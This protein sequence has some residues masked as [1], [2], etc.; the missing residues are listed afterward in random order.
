[1]ADTVVSNL[2]EFKLRR[3]PEGIRV[4]VTSTPEFEQSLRTRSKADRVDRCSADGK[5]VYLWNIRQNPTPDDAELGY[6]L[7]MEG[8]S[9]PGGATCVF[10]GVR[11]RDQ[12]V[13]VA[14][15]VSAWVET[16]FAGF[17]RAIEVTATIKARSVIGLESPTPVMPSITAGA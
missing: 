3:S 15:Q 1:V 11:S 2:V 7:Y 16:H 5:Y 14:E 4:T 17:M 13:K 6:F 10:G 8:S 12:L 9:K